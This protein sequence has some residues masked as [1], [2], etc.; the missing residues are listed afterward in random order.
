MN[1]ATK[2]PCLVLRGLIVEKHQKVVEYPS[3]CVEI[4]RVMVTPTRVAVLGFDVE[5]SNRVVREFIRQRYFETDFLRLNFC[6][7]NGNRLT[8]DDFKSQYI[9]GKISQ[10]LLSPFSINGNQYQFLA[11]SSSQLKEASVWL[12]NCSENKSLVYEIRTWMGDFKDI[13]TPSKYAA[14]MGQCLSTTIET[15]PSTNYR[16]EDRVFEHLLVD[17]TFD[18]ICSTTSTGRQ[19]CHSDGTGLIRKDVLQRILE[20]IP[21]VKHDLDDISTI[22]I[23]IGGAKGTLTAWNDHPNLRFKDVCL[24][25]SM[26]KFPASYN[27]LEVVKVGRHVPYYLN[28]QMIM[29]L[30]VHKVPMKSFLEMQKTMLDDLDSMLINRKKAQTILQGLGGLD[31]C[32]KEILLKMLKC[33]FC[34]KSDP[35]LFSCL[36]ALRNLHLMNLKKKSRIFVAR[37]AVLIGGLD[38]SGEV[39]EGCVFVQLRSSETKEFVPLKGPVLIAKHPV[40]HPG[41]VR[42]LLAVD[43]PNLNEQKNVLLFSKHGIRAEADKMSGSDLDGDEYAVTWDERLFLN[44]WNGCKMIREGVYALKCGRKQLYAMRNDHSDLKSANE[45][46]MEFDTQISAEVVDKVTDEHLVKHFIEFGASDSLGRIAMLWLDHAAKQ[47]SASCQECLKLAELHSV[48]VDYP[49]SGVPAVIPTDL[50][51]PSSA[52]RPHWRERKGTQP[53]HC[54]SAIGKLYDQIIICKDGNKFFNNHAAVAGRNLNKKGQLLCF[55]KSGWLHSKNIYKNGVVIKLNLISSNL[56]E[57]EDMISF[58]LEQKRLYE[59]SLVALMNKYKIYSEGEVLTGCIIKFHKLNKRRQYKVAEEVRRQSRQLYIDCRNDFVK[60]VLSFLLPLD[61]IHEIEMPYYLEWIEIVI[62]APFSSTKAQIHHV[63]KEAAKNDTFL[64]LGFTDI[65]KCREI[66]RKLAAVYYVVTYYPAISEL[67]DEASI[68]MAKMIRKMI[69]V[70]WIEAEYLK[71][72][73]SLFSFPYIVYDVISLAM[74]EKEQSK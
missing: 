19:S 68:K 23:R 20:V 10:F 31:S 26:I 57:F 32:M 64:V 44:E 70:D 71:C 15:L 72:N 60:K 63:L 33:G 58:S 40:T 54:D 9:E 24:R 5:I 39:P 28:R 55:A 16:S 51:I 35:F 41:D 30:G 7:E 18:D 47:K 52:P 42:M 14:R 62:S 37:G 46:P 11:Y 73:H 2:Y 66:G 34:P 65:P 22:Q 69:G 74:L 13:K 50:V 36:H 67:D 27:N 49:K 45:Q 53:Y 12:V 56:V 3:Y 59:D 21:S 25:P 29:L 1:G 48:A 17:D 61:S 43:I 8:N 38:E 4:P 6:D